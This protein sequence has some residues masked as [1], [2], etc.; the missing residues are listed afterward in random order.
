M[1]SETGKMDP[2]G[3][4][5]VL[6]VFSEGSP[7]VAKANIDVSKTYTNRFVDQAKKTSGA[8]AK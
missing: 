1:Y 8:S 3:A 4:E 2:K 5:A 6:A 7:E